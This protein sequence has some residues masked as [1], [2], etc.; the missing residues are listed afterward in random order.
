M[1]YVFTRA[2]P[3]LERGGTFNEVNFFDIIRF[4]DWRV[5]ESSN[6]VSVGF[7]L[8]KETAWIIER[9]AALLVNRFEIFSNIKVEQLAFPLR[10]NDS[11]LDPDFIKW[12]QTLFIEDD[13]AT[14]F[15]LKTAP[16]EN[17]PWIKED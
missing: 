2:Y 8:D 5:K 9:Y 15:G 10:I 14:F 17:N 12:A 4:M 3:D 11:E 1:A 16:T 7:E 6:S 13:I